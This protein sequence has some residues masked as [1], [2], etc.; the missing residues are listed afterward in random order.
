M[1]IMKLREDFEKL[2]YRE[3]LKKKNEINSFITKF[4]TDFNI[5]KIYLNICPK[6][7][8]QFQFYLEEIG[9]FAPL[10]AKVCNEEYEWD[11]KDIRYYFKDMK[12]L[13]SIK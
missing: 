2:S 10:L 8:A 13:I 9:K 6:L 5:T 4:E 11:D 3:L 1:M 12:K 7:D